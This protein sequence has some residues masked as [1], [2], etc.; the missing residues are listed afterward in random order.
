[1]EKGFA[2]SVV[3]AAVQIVAGS[4]RTGQELSGGHK[5]KEAG[6]MEGGDGCP[7]AR[8]DKACIS[9]R[10]TAFHRQRT[11]ITPW[12]LLSRTCVLKATGRSLFLLCS[13]I[14]IVWGVCLLYL[15]WGESEGCSRQLHC[16]P[17]ANLGTNTPCLRCPPQCLRG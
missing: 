11:V 1:M 12:T 8:K 13:L 2:S 10:L 9:R 5:V 3:Q 7:C 14:I 4:L 17:H 6:S 16:K 15:C